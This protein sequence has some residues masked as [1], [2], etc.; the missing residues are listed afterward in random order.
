MSCQKKTN[1]RDDIINN[2]RRDE[3]TTVFR[4]IDYPGEKG[5]HLLKKYF[6]K[7]V[8]STNQQVNSACQNSN[9]KIFSCQNFLE[10]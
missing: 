9:T 1:K 4:N 6:R 8:G 5:E 10:I 3:T 2:E 7:L